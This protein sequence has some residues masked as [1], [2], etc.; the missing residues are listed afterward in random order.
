MN[1]N[2]KSIHNLKDFKQLRNIKY[3]GF[4]NLKNKNCGLA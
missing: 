3:K 4:R 2:N 1:T